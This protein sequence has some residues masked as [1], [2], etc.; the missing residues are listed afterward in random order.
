MTIRRDT[1][2]LANANLMRRVHA[3]V[4]ILDRT[5]SPVI[6]ALPDG[7]TTCAELNHS[8]AQTP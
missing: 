7:D 8:S 4:V 3:G 1:T 2:A 5:T 6:P